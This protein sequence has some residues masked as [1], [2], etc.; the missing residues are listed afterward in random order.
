MSERQSGTAKQAEGKENKD[1]KEKQPPA[2]QPNQFVRTGVKEADTP[3]HGTYNLGGGRRG[4][5]SAPSG[6]SN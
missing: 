5:I 6:L 2:K 4:A 3:V 1:G